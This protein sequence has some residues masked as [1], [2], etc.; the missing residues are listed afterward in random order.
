MK[1]CY[2]DFCT[3]AYL[4]KYSLSSHYEEK[5]VKTTFKSSTLILYQAKKSRSNNQELTKTLFR[6]A[7][8]WIW[9]PKG[10]SLTQLYLDCSFRQK[11]ESAFKSAFIYCLSK[12]SLCY[13]YFS[14]GIVW[15]IRSW[16]D[17]LVI[18]K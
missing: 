7:E 11:R 9:S 18:K 15:S 5:S 12:F 3:F 1:R 16:R 2:D 8:N 17:L 14:I 6:S 4:S 13:M 10:L